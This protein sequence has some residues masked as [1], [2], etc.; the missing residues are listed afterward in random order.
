MSEDDLQEAI[1]TYLR[2]LI[3]YEL[4]G[5]LGFMHIANESGLRAGIGWHAK[6][7]RMGLMPGVAD[8]L[9]LFPGGVSVWVELKVDRLKTKRADSLQMLSESQKDFRCMVKGLGFNHSV[10]ACKTL[11]EG[12]EGIERIIAT[13]L[14]EF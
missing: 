9:L 2:S 4:K 10:L 11:D 7:K 3:N 13:E 14:G 6:R 5:R 12:I 8:L 1:V